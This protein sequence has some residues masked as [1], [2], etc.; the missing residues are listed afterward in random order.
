M[1]TLSR[2]T[3]G[4]I[5]QTGRL[6]RFDDNEAICRM[7]ECADGL[8]GLVTGGAEIRLM[9]DDGVLT[10]VHRTEP[11]FWCGAS[12]IFSDDPSLVSVIATR[13]TVALHLPITRLRA[14]ADADPQLHRDF[15]AL[16]HRNLATALRL[17][18]NLCVAS[19]ERR[20]ALRLAHY[21]EIAPEPGNWIFVSQG[22]LA[23]LIAVSLPTL[24]RALRR[25][26]RDGLVEVGYGK[27]RIPDRD[28]LRAH[29]SN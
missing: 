19:S 15:H 23:D 28:A 29:S 24:Q 13:P 5:L 7:G 8:V 16:S 2:Q 21:D 14:L 11:G 9:G 3:Q 4:K 10:A 22:A 18:G 1:N 17:V 6:A 26:I 25:F 20:L 12:A 27:L